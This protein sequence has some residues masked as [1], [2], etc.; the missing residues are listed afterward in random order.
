MHKVVV[1]SFLFLFCCSRVDLANAQKGD[2]VFTI[3]LVRHSEKELNINNP[4]DPPLNSCGVKRADHLRNF[5]YDVHLNAV[6]STDYL[7]TKN[8]ALP[9]AL[10]KRLPIKIYNPGD[11]EAFS[12]LLLE[13]KQDVLV[14]GHSNTTGVLAGLLVGENL[15]SFDESIYERIYKVVVYKNKGQLHLLYSSF[16][17]TD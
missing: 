5:L 8:T 2:D 6:Y 13:A 11:L 16:D 1:L 14:V 4:S 3:Y 10:S 15:G 7:R 12:S 9:T 17:C